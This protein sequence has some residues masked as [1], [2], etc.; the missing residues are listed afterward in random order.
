MFYGFIIVEAAIIQHLWKYE[1]QWWGDTYEKEKQI[2]NPLQ[3]K[4]IERFSYF[5]FPS[6]QNQ[7]GKFNPFVAIVTVKSV[8]TFNWRLQ[9]N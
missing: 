3:T 6:T 5:F 7:P 9:R 1:L 2:K 8:A 4:L